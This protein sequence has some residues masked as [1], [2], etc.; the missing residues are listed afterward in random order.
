MYYGIYK[1]I[2]VINHFKNEAYIFCHFSDEQ[3]NID[4]IYQLIKVSS[5]SIKFNSIDDINSV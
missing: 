3:N 4:K 5:T 2:I 1:N